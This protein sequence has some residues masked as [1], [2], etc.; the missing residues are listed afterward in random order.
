MTSDNEQD[1]VRRYFTD[2]EWTKMPDFLK[3]RC[4]NIKENYDM[5]I[6]A[7]LHPPVPDFMTPKPATLTVPAEHNSRDPTTCAPRP[8]ARKR[9]EGQRTERKKPPEMQKATKASNLPKASVS[10]PLRSNGT[11]GNSSTESR[12]PKRCRKEMNYAEKYVFS[13][14]EDTDPD[15]GL[16]SEGSTLKGKKTKTRDTKANATSGISHPARYRC[17]RLDPRKCPA[18][19]PSGYGEDTMASV[20]T[21]ERARQSLPEG[22]VIHRSRLKGAQLGVFAVASLDEEVCFGPY[23]SP[24]MQNGDGNPSSLEN[25]RATEELPAANSRLRTAMWMR[26]VNCA[27]TGERENLV[28][29]YKDGAVY[30]ST[31]KKIGPD[32]EL[33]VWCGD[34][35]A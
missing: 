16:S 23:R 29:T 8:A 5:M 27:P 30:Y 17:M 3:Q 11:P 24:D 22:L 2:D 6:A 7:G 21:F 9:V 28:P 12:Y 33:L 4:A 14:N 26:Y 13:D 18:H 31:C 32:D 15:F 25:R 35:S 34:T 19:G 10:D 20:E 1:G